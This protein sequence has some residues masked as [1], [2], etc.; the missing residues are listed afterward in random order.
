M[1]KCSIGLEVVMNR[2]REAE[3]GCL[4]DE[5]QD[6]VKPIE[7]PDMVG[8]AGP[9]RGRCRSVALE[10]APLTRGAGRVHGSTNGRPDE[11]NTRQRTADAVCSAKVRFPQHRESYAG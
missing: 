2:V 11:E 7:R 5:I 10:V 9:Q 4:F 3:V 1:R 6:L 8:P